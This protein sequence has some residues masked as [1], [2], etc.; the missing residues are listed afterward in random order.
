M[1]KARRK[2]NDN[3]KDLKLFLKSYPRI[4]SHKKVFKNKAE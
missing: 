1:K 2:W 4:Y 3:F